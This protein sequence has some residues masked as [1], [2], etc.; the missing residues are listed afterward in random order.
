MNS[1]Y[2]D[3]SDDY[4]TARVGKVKIII[5]NASKRKPYIKFVDEFSRDNYTNKMQLLIADSLNSFY[6]KIF[7]LQEKNS[8]Y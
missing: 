3:I 8:F 6:S 2:F 5:K 1:F 7:I 4:Y